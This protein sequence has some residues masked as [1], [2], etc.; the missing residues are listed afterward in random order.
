VIEGMRKGVRFLQGFL[1]FEGHFV[2]SH[3]VSPRASFDSKDTAGSRMG[4][5][6]RPSI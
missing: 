5:M 1:R 6:T 4:Q 2:V 3:V